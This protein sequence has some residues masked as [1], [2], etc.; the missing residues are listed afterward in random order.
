MT[1]AREP[2]ECQFNTI[3][4]TL[5]RKLYCA[6]SASH[7]S[8]VDEAQV[9]G[10]VNYKQE[11]QLRAVDELVKFIYTDTPMEVVSR[12]ITIFNKVFGC[13]RKPKE[14]LS[15]FVSRLLGLAAD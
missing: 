2:N 13:K 11:N 1:A 3:R 4:A 14:S 15:T 5:G 7:R 9:R 10:I 12:L 8:V 6:L